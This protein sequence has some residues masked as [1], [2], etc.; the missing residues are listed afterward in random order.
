M[1]FLRP[2]VAQR[3]RELVGLVVVIIVAVDPRAAE[4]ASFYLSSSLG[5]RVNFAVVLLRKHRLQMGKPIHLNRWPIPGG[6][7]FKV[8]HPQ[9][10]DLAAAA[11]RCSTCWRSRTTA[12]VH[13]APRAR[14]LL[15][16][17]PE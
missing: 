9:R 12:P 16:L 17:R 13:S 11:R 2:R 4:E 6:E 3:A 15:E 14:A 5:E 7:R 1:V 10:D 8:K